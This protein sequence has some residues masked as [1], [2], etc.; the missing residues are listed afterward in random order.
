VASGRG[1]R[2]PPALGATDADIVDVPILYMP[3]RDFP[4][5]ADALTAGMVNML[6]LNGHCVVPKPFGPEVAG[7][8][9]FEADL[10]TNLSGLGLRVWFI[11][12]WHEYHVLLGEVHCGTN[13]LRRVRANPRCWEFTP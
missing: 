12:D 11:D 9:R 7:V 1:R 13:T 5:F 2:G 8:D 3:N 6:V 10:Q 4:A